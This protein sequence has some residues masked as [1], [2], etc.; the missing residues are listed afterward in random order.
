[1]DVLFVVIVVVVGYIVRLYVNYYVV[2]FVVV[3]LLDCIECFLYVLIVGWI[4]DVVWFCLLL[5]V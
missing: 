5:C 2:Y 3:F 1:M 4:M